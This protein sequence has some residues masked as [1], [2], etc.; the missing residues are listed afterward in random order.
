MKTLMLYVCLSLTMTA[1]FLVLYSYYHSIRASDDQWSHCFIAPAQTLKGYDYSY[2]TNLLWHHVE[3]VSLC[4]LTNQMAPEHLSRT[5]SLRR[6]VD[7]LMSK[8]HEVNKI[9]VYML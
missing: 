2:I 7:V 4:V 9:C 8:I 1:L 3:R 5:F 6:T